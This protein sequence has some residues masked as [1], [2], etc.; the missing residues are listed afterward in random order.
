M[1]DEVI[2][3]WVVFFIM[4]F[5]NMKNV[6]WFNFFLSYIYGVDFVYDEM[7]IIG[8]GDEGC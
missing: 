4:V 8:F 6:Y 5:I 1:E 2:G 7:M 3:G